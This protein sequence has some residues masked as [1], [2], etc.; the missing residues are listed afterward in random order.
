MQA[1]IPRKLATHIA[2]L[3]AYFPVLSITGPRQAGKTTLLK[4][5][6]GDYRY[7]SLEDIPL[8]EA[9]ADDPLAFLTTYGRRVIFDEAQRVPD[10]FSYLQTRVDEDR[11]P[12]RFV[13]SG[14]QNFLLSERISQSLA[15]RVGVVRLLPF[16]FGELRA[17][18]LLPNSPPEAILRGFYPQLYQTD[19]PPGFFYPS[20][21]STYLDRDVTPL[22]RRG[23]RGDFRRLMALC[24]ASVG[25][26][27]NF[28]SLAKRLQ[29][30]VP[31]IKTWLHYLEESYLIFTVG[32]YYENF[33]KRLVKTPKIYFYDTGLAAYLLRL[34]TPE[35]VRRS[36]LYGALF[37]NLIVANLRKSRYH[38]GNQHP[39]YYYRDNHGL[40]VDLL[41]PLPGGG[42][43][44]TE[45]KATT[46][47]RS[48]LRSG[49]DK[50]A[51]LVPGAVERRIIYGGEQPMAVDGVEVHP[52]RGE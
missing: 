27:I 37:E 24:A 47:Y 43:R 46:T 8:R 11:T 4:E 42:L 38:D 14:S 6:F 49:L 52:W 12:G 13:L 32:P 36:E 50:V 20:Y 30:S 22:V 39:L 3:R 48:R 17:V 45:I 41:E 19:L 35:Q 44:L 7:L 9:F 15:G 2:E 29:L 33:G 16:D 51:A 25:Q 23:N 21:V 26:T 28:S 5:L 40:E 31:T 18:G 34:E 1:F 10:L